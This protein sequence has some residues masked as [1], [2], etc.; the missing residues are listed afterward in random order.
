MNIS[1]VRITHDYFEGMDYFNKLDDFNCGVKTMNDFL[2]FD[3]RKLDEVGEGSTYL[4]IDEDTK[5]LIGYYTIKC[6]SIQIKEG[7]YPKVFP[8]IEVSRFAI[9]ESYQGIGLSQSLFSDLIDEI[10]YINDNYVGVKFITLF[11]ISDKSFKFYSDF[12]FEVG[13]EE[14]TIV[15]EDDINYNCTFMFALL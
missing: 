11:S 9:T 8:A 14:T 13:N 3:A 7:R 12:D 10:R 4:Y 5:S 15:L 6:S 1:T 2:N